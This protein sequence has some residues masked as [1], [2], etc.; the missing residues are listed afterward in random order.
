MSPEGFAPSKFFLDPGTGTALDEYVMLFQGLSLYAQMAARAKDGV[1]LRRTQRDFELQFY[2]GEED[3]VADSVFLSWLYLDFAYG[4]PKRTVCERFLETDTPRRL[5]DPGPTFLRQLAAS[6]LGWYE[7]EQMTAADLRFREVGTDRLWRV[8]R[9]NEPED[10]LIKER[11][12]WYV[13]LLGT[14]EEAV[15]FTAPL[16]LPPEAKRDV[17]QT[18]QVGLK[19]FAASGLSDE[20]RLRA[21]CKVRVRDWLPWILGPTIPGMEASPTLVN[22]D[23]EPLRF[24]NVYFKIKSEEGLTDQLRRVPGIYHVEQVKDEPNGPRIRANWMKAGNRRIPTWEN[25]ILGHIK[26]QQGRLVGETNSLERALRLKRL[27]Q[28]KLKAHLVYE[29]IESRDWRAVPPPSPKELRKAEQERRSLMAKPEVRAAYVA[30]IKAYYRSW[31]DTPIPALGN[32]TPRKTAQ[33]AR[34]KARVEELVCDIEADQARQPSYYPKADL[35]FLRL[36]LGLPDR[37]DP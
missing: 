16:I 21:C 3:G 34:G 9:V 8:L 5:R 35:R 27:L 18:V 20:D 22:T 23:Q 37:Q 28:R 30:E 33:T 29:R 19:E 14:P 4:T 25:T 13:R 26:V 1:A 17:R 15:I 2:P 6:Y 10:R 11:E 31:L 7:L 36:E 12:L 24:S 32:R